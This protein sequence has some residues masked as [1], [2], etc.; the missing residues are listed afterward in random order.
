MVSY[1]VILSL[2][3]ST[4]SPLLSSLI[5]NIIAFYL[6]NIIYSC[7]HIMHNKRGITFRHKKVH[8]FRAVTQ[9]N[10]ILLCSWVLCVHNPV[11]ISTRFGVLCLYTVGKVP[12]W[13]DTDNS[14]AGFTSAEICCSEIYLLNIDICS[15][16]YKIAYVFD[17]VI[18]THLSI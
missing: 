6:C 10:L 1:F 11:S 5:S 2:S 7:P 12:R 14:L 17:A 3:N 8:I 4:S 9:P 16:L 18:C 15:G 13:W